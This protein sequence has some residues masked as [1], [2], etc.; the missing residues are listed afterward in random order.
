M[1]ICSGGDPGRNLSDEPVVRVSY[2]D[3]MRA[4]FISR[5]V[6]EL[7]N[8]VQSGQVIGAGGP[9]LDVGADCAE[10]RFDSAKS[11]DL[12]QHKPHILLTDQ[13]TLMKVA[14]AA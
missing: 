14:R 7:S 1:M 5:R 4:V 2:L 9:M 6:V 10:G 8:L 3:D 11:I 12:G 13:Q